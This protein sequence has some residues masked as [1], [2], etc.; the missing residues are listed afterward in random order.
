MNAISNISLDE[1]VIRNNSFFSSDMDGEKV[2]LSV[3]TGKYYNLGEVGGDIWELLGTRLRVSEL[4]S[5]L[6][7]SYDVE[8]EVCQSEVISFLEVLKREGL[9]EIEHH[10]NT[11]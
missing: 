4:I 8:F 11:L 3:K 6:T 1:V 5:R 2:L 7:K 9:V 10:I